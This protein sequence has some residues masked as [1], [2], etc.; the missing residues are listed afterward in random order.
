MQSVEVEESKMKME[1]QVVAEYSESYGKEGE[2]EIE[3]E[4]EREIC[5]HVRKCPKDRR[6]E[7]K[8]Y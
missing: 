5:V 7:E 6:K 3:R 4:R 2:R 8:I 1:K